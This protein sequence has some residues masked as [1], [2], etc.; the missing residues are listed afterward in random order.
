MNPSP[1]GLGALDWVAKATGPVA[2]WLRVIL[3]VPGERYAG[4]YEMA[5]VP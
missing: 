4:G 5:V 3:Y 1:Y 2:S